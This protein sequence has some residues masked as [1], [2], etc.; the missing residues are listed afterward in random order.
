VKKPGKSGMVIDAPERASLTM[1]LPRISTSCSKSAA[2]VT[3]EK[4]LHSMA[5]PRMAI[6]GLSWDNVSS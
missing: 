4:R 5:K 2:V 1:R 6:R 3:G